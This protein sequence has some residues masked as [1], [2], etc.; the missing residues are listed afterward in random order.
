MGYT[1]ELSKFISN[2]SE[3]D[4]PDAILEEVRCRT[5]DWLGCA[6]GSLNKRSVREILTIITE[7]GGN[8]QSTVLGVSPKTSTGNAAFAN[9]IMGHAL[10]YDDVDKTSISHPGALAIPVALAVSER[11]EKDF[12]QYA[13]GVI[14]G[15][16]V[17]IRLG[18]SLNPSHYDYW[19]TT[20]TCGT[21]AAAATAARI[22]NFSP[23]ELEQSMGIAGTMVSGL[24]CVFG[25]DAK[26]VNVGNAA[27]N[28]IVSAELVK[29]GFTAPSGIIEMEN[30]YASA[31]CTEKDLSMITPKTGDTL[32]IR[33]AYYKI[34]ASCGHTHS[35]LDALS[36]LMSENDFSAKDVLHIEV[37]AYRKAIELTRELKNHS[38]QEAK[39]SMPYCLAVMLLYGEVTANKFSD[40]TLHDEHILNLARK[41]TVR[42]NPSF[43]TNYPA[44]R[45]ERVTLTLKDR[46][47]TK[48]VE[49]SF[50]KPPIDFIKH[51]FLLLAGNTIGTKSAHSIAEIV[52]SAKPETN[53]SEYMG[54]I[55]K[56]L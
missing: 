24:V 22:M 38:E 10:E 14:V 55:R 25:T 26:L 34:H 42:E 33:N 21:F 41:I 15:Y 44:K 29:H 50:G 31:T 6:I 56:E 53:I 2:L 54:K 27:R 17:M 4:I 20:G 49:L 47:L 23:R 8:P 13:I 12:L 28:G 5:L 51:K 39:F 45:L 18:S 11:Y 1:Y 7:I 48:L 46:N 32:M 3:S 37:E 9:S 52:L 43:T 30:G 19:H 36:E 16:E 40:E 35:A